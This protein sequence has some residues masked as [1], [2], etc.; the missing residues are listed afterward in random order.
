M[1][2]RSEYASDNWRL[3]SKGQKLYPLGLQFKYK[4][5]PLP[6][7]DVDKVVHSIISAAPFDR[8]VN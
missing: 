5:E 2:K 3:K 7:G 8:K 6:F 4:D 1:R